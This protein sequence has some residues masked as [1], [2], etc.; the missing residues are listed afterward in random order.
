M[1]DRDSDFVPDISDATWA[2]NRWPTIGLYTGA[3]IGA[4]LGVVF[5][6]GWVWTILY[7][8][9]LAMAGCLLGLVMAKLVYRPAGE[10]AEDQ[11]RAD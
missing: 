3:S 1:G 6:V 2:H 4:V 9:G 8:V 7:V 11:E 10:P 5:Y